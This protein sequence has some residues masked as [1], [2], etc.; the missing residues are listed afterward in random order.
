MT[1]LHAE[2]LA[3]AVLKLSFFLLPNPTRP[4]LMHTFGAA[5]LLWMA[6]GIADWVP[7]GA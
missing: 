5:I 4:Q 3:K 7:L 6:R 1:F 2:D